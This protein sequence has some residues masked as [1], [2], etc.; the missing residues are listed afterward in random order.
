MIY[1]RETSNKM[2]WLTGMCFLY[3]EL[4]FCIS[5]GYIPSAHYHMG[6]IPFLERDHL[7]R[8]PRTETPG[9]RHPWPE[10]PDRES[11]GQRQPWTETSWTETPYLDRHPTW[12]E[13]TLTPWTENSPWT[14]RPVLWTESQ[15]GVKTQPFLNFVAGSVQYCQNELFFE[16]LHA[17]MA[18]ILDE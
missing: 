4:N 10:T 8:D 11:P 7:G 3:S 18:L 1:F 14:E 17:L 12:T 5:V 2:W 15:T 13:T 9:L 16:K 6:G